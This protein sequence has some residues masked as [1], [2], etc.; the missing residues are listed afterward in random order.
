MLGSRSTPGGHLPPRT[1]A[2]TGS[3]FATASASGSA[4]STGTTGRSLLDGHSK[5]KCSKCTRLTE[6]NAKI[7]HFERYPRR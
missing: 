6:D 5:T 2:A 1:F 7:I 4:I 3:P